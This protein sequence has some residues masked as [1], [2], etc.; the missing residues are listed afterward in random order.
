MPLFRDCLNYC[1]FWVLK[2]NLNDFVPTVSMVYI[3]LFYVNFFGSSSILTEYCIGFSIISPFTKSFIWVSCSLCVYLILSNNLASSSALKDLFRYS[4]PIIVPGKFWHVRLITTCCKRIL[5]TSLSGTIFCNWSL[6]KNCYYLY[7]F[8][9]Y[10]LI[11]MVLFLSSIYYWC[12][13]LIAIILF[14]YY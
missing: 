11:F 9:Y 14:T 8:N 6:T 5:L 13:L 2:I 12:Y 4:N 3:N 7:S 10:S 1:G